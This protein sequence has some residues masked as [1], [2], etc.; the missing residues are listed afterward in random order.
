MKKKLFSVLTLALIAGTIIISMGSCARKADKTSNLMDTI[1]IQKQM[2]AWA[3]ASNIYEVNIR[4]YTPEGTFKAFATHLP[5]LQK[6]GVDILWL[7]PISPV[8]EKNRKGS[9]GSYYSIRNYTAV[10]PEFGTLEDFKTLISEAHKLGMHVIIDWVA[11][12]T[13]WD[14]VWMEEHKDWYTQD[15]LGNVI[16]PAG[17]DW[18]DTAD[19]NYDNPELRKAMIDALAY[20]VKEADIDGFRCDVAGMIPLT[21][22]L[23]ARKAIDAIKPDCFFLAEDGE[24]VIH[25]AFDMTYNW[26][27]KDLIN[28]TAKGKKNAADIVNL[29]IEEQSR[30]KPEDL[31]MQFITNHDENS[32]SGTEYDRLGKEAVDAFNVLI[33]MIPGMP[34]TYTG[35]EEP[36]LKMLRFFDKDTVGF[37]NYVRQELLTKLNA[38]KHDNPALWNISYGGE[39]KMLSSSAP[40]S[41]MGILRIKNENKVL[42]V[43]NLSAKE[44][45]FQLKDEITGTFKKY[46]GADFN[47]ASKANYKLKAWEYVV[48]V[49]EK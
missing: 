47:P 34:L 22:W 13:S 5:R 36:M 40:E 35:Q 46:L 4:Q 11:N 37:I 33:Y 3:K 19:L 15:S 43:F 39:F 44:V 17:T 31:R 42:S 6:M 7:M 18:H 48:M 49:A 38:L 28:A 24:P 30:F 23:H 45:S 25:Q 1:L 8:G 20:W 27:L 14:N 16:I 2:P 29:L 12:H 41:I 9:L 32:W 10:N 21:F 26:P